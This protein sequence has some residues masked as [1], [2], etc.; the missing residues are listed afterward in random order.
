MPIN[1][2]IR[3]ELLELLRR[4]H[5]IAREGSLVPLRVACLERKLLGTTIAAMAV[6]A[7]D[8]TRGGATGKWPSLEALALAITKAGEA[9]QNRTWP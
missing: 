9:V 5:E 3:R 1:D 4:A 6:S 7:V 2:D 8:A